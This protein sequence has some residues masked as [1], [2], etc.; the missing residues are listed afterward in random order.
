MVK[1][2]T[3]ISSLYIIFFCLIQVVSQPYDVDVN[4]EYAIRGN[5]VVLKCTVPSF[6]SDFLTVVSWHTDAGEV[7]YPNNDNYGKHNYLFTIKMFL[8]SLTQ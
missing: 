1:E 8:T 3:C 7:F 6:V 4:K 5:S 2:A